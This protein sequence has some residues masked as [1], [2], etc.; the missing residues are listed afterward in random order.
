MCPL[1]C[2]YVSSLQ[3][4][5]IVAVRASDERFLGQ[6]NVLVGEGQSFIM[7]LREKNIVMR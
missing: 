3:G 2:R 1:L 5:F 6:G 4:W 7:P